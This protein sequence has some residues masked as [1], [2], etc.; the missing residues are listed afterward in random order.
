MTHIKINRNRRFWQNYGISETFMH[1]YWDWKTVCPY[2]KNCLA[3]SNKVK[4]ISDIMTA[5]L[6]PG[7]VNV[8]IVLETCAQIFMAVLFIIVPN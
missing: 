7:H 6:L 5:T 3:I 4:A 1:F 8:D 2:W